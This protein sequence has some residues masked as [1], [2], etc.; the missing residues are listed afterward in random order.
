MNFGELPG[1]EVSSL[2]VVIVHPFWD[3]FAPRE[4]LARA[5]AE[6]VIAYDAQRVKFLDVFNLM[7]RESWCYERLAH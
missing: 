1:F 7:R 6:T 3:T 2:Q 4:M 5:A